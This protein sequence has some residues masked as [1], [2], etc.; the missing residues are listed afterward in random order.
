MIEKEHNL[1]ILLSNP[2]KYKIPE[3]KSVINF[4][5]FIKEKI[6]NTHIVAYNEIPETK[7]SMKGNYMKNID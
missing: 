4:K 2:G 7:R 3:V 5:D 1:K 6:T